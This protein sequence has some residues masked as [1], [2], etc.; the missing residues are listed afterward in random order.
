MRDHFGTRLPCS[1]DVSKMSAVPA[2]G[3]TL[4]LPPHSQSRST[5]TRSPRRPA[6]R[7]HRRADGRFRIGETERLGVHLGRDVEIVNGLL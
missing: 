2:P 7:Q 3:G 6:A 1:S 5:P 4:P